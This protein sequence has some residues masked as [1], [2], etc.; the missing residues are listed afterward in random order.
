MPR[1]AAKWALVVILV[2]FLLAGCVSLEKARQL[3]D[4]A[5]QVCR[6][7]DGVRQCTQD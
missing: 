3:F 2:P 5:S 1:T 7:I 4:T 6:I